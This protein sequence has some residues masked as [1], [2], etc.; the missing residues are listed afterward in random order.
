MLQICQPMA[1]NAAAGGSDRGKGYIF[2]RSGTTWTEID[3]ITGS[4]IEDSEE[5]GYAVDMSADGTYII[6]SSWK[7][8]SQQGA[9]YI[10]KKSGT[11]WT[12][13]AK[14][15]ASDGAIGENSSRGAAYVFS[16]SGTTWT[17]QQKLTVSD[18]AANDAFGLGITMSA[19]GR[20][21]LIGAIT[22]DGAGTDRG[23]TYMFQRN[24]STWTEI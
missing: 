7:H 22:E 17:E 11:G 23:A 15:E 10:F 20:H 5:L 21:V 4:D 12:Q 3:T 16:R 13:Q 2:S 14:L 1:D 6:T 8:N 24:D 19:D 18:A 9:A